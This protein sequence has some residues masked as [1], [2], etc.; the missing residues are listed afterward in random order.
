MVLIL[1][2]LCCISL[3]TSLPVFVKSQRNP[4]IEAPENTDALL[5]STILLKCI[6]DMTASDNDERVRVIWSKDDFG[7]GGSRSEI[8]E[9]RTTKSGTSKYDLPNNLDQG[10]YNAFSSRH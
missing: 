9:Y 2:T 3:L 1:P 5:N 6:V 7:I 10:K 4:I 8:R